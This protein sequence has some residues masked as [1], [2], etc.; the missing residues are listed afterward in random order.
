MS[1][2]DFCQ[3]TLNHWPELKRFKSRQ[4][5]VADISPAQQEQSAREGCQTDGTDRKRDD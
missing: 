5:N 3:Q 1:G 2:K 4:T